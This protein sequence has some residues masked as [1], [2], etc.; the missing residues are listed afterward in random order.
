MSIDYSQ[1][2]IP[3]GTPR[4]LDRIEKKRAMEK[5]ERDCRRTVRARDKGKCRVCGR[6]AQHMHHL[7]RRSLGGK[8]TPRNVVHLC[9]ICHQ[10]EHAALLHISGDPER[11]IQVT[12]T[13]EAS[14][15]IRKGRRG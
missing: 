9:R 6:P 10:F 1:F 7:E 3:K 13:G 15:Y 2:A 11:R 12:S 8:W 4:I 5:Q 14:L